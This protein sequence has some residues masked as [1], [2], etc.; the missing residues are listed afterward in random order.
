MNKFAAFLK[1]SLLDP[2]I[3]S[4]FRF[5][6]AIIWSVI[7][8]IVTIIEM[9]VTTTFPFYEV[10]AVMW[11]VLP[12]L[13]FKTL[14]LERLKLPNYW[15]YVLTA[16]ILLLGVAYFF[17]RQMTVDDGVMWEIR[18]LTL[19]AIALISGLT[20]SYFPKRENFSTY[21]IYLASKFF[22]TVFYSAVLWGGLSAVFGSVEA[23]FN[24]N[25]GD[26][27]FLEL[28]T[29]VVGLVSVPVFLG[30]APKI[31]DVMGTEQ[32]SKI[33]KTVF[34]FI[35]LPIV[36]IFSFILLLYVVTSTINSNYYPDVYLISS[37]AVAF[38]GLITIL[39]LEPFEKE[40][41]HI[42]FFSKW[43]PIVLMAIFVGF[44]FEMIR[45]IIDY[46]MT[47]MSTTYL[48]LSFWVVA[49]AILHFI[50]KYPLKMKFGQT[51]ASAMVCT[52]LFISYVPYINV[53]S[54]ATYSLNNRFERLLTEYGMVENGEIVHA[55]DPL[56][57]TEMNTIYTMV[58]S[59]Y[60]IGYS[61]IELLPDNYVY[62]DFET[63]FGFPD[64][65]QYEETDMFSIYYKA[66]NSLV[67]LTPLLSHEVLLILDA[68]GSLVSSETDFTFE[69]VMGQMN[70]TLTIDSPLTVITLPMDD[71]ALAVYQDVGSP[72]T[73]APSTIYDFTY[74]GV[75]G[76]VNY[77]IYFT[78]LSAEYNGATGVMYINFFSMYIGIDYI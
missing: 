74:S 73:E 18:H 43:W 1:G 22:A 76:T 8:V 21:L 39:V 24:V 50:R 37:L 57:V 2:F 70:W 71:I 36:T 60:E 31:D 3:R 47:L 67:D 13:I 27:F 58:Q 46:G 4:F 72:T 75:Y 32:Y 59:F 56:T 25:L 78:E 9:E 7:L 16:S 6:E 45:G 54:I 30:F 64:E 23:L 61:R 12:F 44:Y 35:I 77:D 48:Y 26:Y 65:Y 68:N 15:K 55:T 20:V 66:D 51:L 69:K 5:T 52:L 62:T 14:L 29:A 11:L 41:A 40:T 10:I 63:V 49:C 33:W 19:W 28:F 42:H 53:L 34:S 38:V 17:I